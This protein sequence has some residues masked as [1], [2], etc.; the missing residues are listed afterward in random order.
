MF[1]LSVALSITLVSVS[2]EFPLPTLGTVQSVAVKGQLLCDGKPAKNVKLK[3]YDV[4]FADPD[5]LMAEGKT[6]TNGT[7]LLKG[8]E[9]E[10]TNIDP[11]LN[12]YHNCNDE[13]HECLRKVEIHIPSDFITQGETEPKKTFNV[14]VI[15]L[16]AKLPG[17]SRDCIN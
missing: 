3:L 8:H 7:F 13:R 2:A 11:K 5:D 17:E 15:D 16:K 9:T 6:D 1:P 14:N 4:D 12:I 10:V